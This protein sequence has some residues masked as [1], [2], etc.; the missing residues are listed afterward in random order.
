MLV[1]LILW[2]GSVEALQRAAGPRVSPERPPW[3]VGR[4]LGRA[5]LLVLVASAIVGAVAVTL[6]RPGFFAPLLAVVIER[7][8]M[9]FVFAL[10]PLP[11]VVAAGGWWLR[12]QHARH[13]FDVEARLAGLPPNDPVF[14]PPAR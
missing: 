13:W 3:T 4:L 1:T 6:A 14:G 8:W 9:V 11:P 10:G 5:F 2:L 12:R 7:P